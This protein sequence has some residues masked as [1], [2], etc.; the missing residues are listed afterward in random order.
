MEAY[1]R[2]FDVQQKNTIVDRLSS[3][4]FMAIPWYFVLTQDLTSNQMQVRVDGSA[5]AQSLT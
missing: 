2:I 4:V 3:F 5:A 1:D